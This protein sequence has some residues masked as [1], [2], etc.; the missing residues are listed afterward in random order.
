MTKSSIGDRGKAAEKAVETVLKE[1]NR[2]TEFAY[3]RLPDARS[4]RSFLAAQPGDFAYFCKGKGGLI[5][6]KETEHNYRIAKDK[7]SQLAILQKLSCAGA[8]NV[9][10]VHHSTID[11]WRYILPDQLEIG[12]PSWNLSEFVV[13]ESAAEALAATNFF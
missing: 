6:V 12:P 10:L 5:E 7:I 9:I 11:V 4:A 2:R 13:F 1:F 3:W 8:Q